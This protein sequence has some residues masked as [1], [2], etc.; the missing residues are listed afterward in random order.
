[1]K[2]PKIAIV[3]GSKNDLPYLADVEPLLG[4]FGIA[5]RIVVASAHRQPAKV[6]AFARGAEKEGCEVVIACAGYAAHL[7]GVIAAL[8]AL[9][10]IG[11]PLDTS[12]LRGQDALLSIVQMPGGVPVAA[13]TIGKAG[14]RNA[15]VFAAEILALKYP[16]VKAALTAYRRELAR[17]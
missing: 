17:G 10:V 3:L 4:R 14:V 15:A 9:P 5:H 2:S 16:E 8:T 6:A 7:P 1:M 13:V 12:P 11:V